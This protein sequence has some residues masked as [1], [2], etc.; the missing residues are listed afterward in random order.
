MDLNFAGLEMQ[1]LNIPMDKIKKQTKKWDR[2]SG[3]H[4]Y[5]RSYGHE[6]VKN[7][8]FFVFSTGDSKKSVTV[9]IK[10]LRTSEKSYLALSENAM[11]CWI[12]SYRQYSKMSTLENTEFRYFLADL[13][14]FLIFLTSISHE[15]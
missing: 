1:K 12:L 7:G 9:W 11:D 3:Y 8:S 5:S 15:Q 14:V 4:V 13:K 6:N 2:L 10:Y